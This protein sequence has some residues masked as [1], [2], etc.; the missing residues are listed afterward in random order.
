MPPLVPLPAQVRTTDGSLP[1]DGLRVVAG[2][3]AEEQR[4]ATVA[5]DLLG[6]AGETSG[7]P[8]LVLTLDDAAG[9]DD[10]T[11]PERYT[12]EV[13]PAGAT[14]TAP[15]TEGLFR[16][17]TTLAQLA[18]TDG[19]GRTVLPAV[20]VQ[21]APRYA[22]R[23]LS[24]DVA[25]HF[26]EPDVVERVIDEMARYK[27]SVL[28]LHLTDD[29]GWRLELPSRPL[30]TEISGK[31]EIGDGVGGFYTMDE[32]RRLQEYAAER[33]VQV[34][35]EFD[36][37]GHTN[38]ATHA[39]GELVPGGEPTDR[40]GGEEVGFSKLSFDLPGTEPFL[41]DVFG[42]MA[43]ATLGEYVHIGGDEVFTLGAEEYSRFV[44]L[45]HEVV[46]AAGKKVV[47]W[48]EIAEAELPAGT[49][50]QYWETRKDTEPLRRAV[51]GGAKILLSPADRVY[52][53]MKYDA[54]DVRGQDWGASMPPVELRDSYD[55]EPDAA[56]EGVD[57]DAVVGVEAAIWSERIPDEDTLFM[58]L[59]PRLAASA[60]VAW[61]PADARSWDDFAS[62]VSRESA[63][64]RERGLTFHA[65]PGVD[66]A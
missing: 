2:P 65:S 36:M 38:A 39:Y 42:D 12:V 46:T 15:T 9:P 1:L 23:G 47:G 27:L 48:Q 18:T 51:D 56:V 25:R 7:G 24:L 5:R 16:G 3:S 4:L 54:D 17:L 29:Q 20:V 6:P 62:R 44:L 35:P 31:G 64:W 13:A 50:V 40:F 55:W 43:A 49:V 19:E 57:G 33:Y 14:V 32:F 28:H 66:W 11:S 53:D 34:V 30:L 58:R 8:A 61:T 52:L 60:E 37:P 22:W 63:G 26:F 45:A 21:D 41:R 59:L 10:A